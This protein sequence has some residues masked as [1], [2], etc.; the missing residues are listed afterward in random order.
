MAREQKELINLIKTNTKIIQIV[1]YKTLRIHA[2]LAN[3]ASEL[4]REL[5]LWNRVEEIKKWDTEKR[6]WTVF[7]EAREPET[8]FAFF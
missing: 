7:E 3:A 2:Y 4:G 5:Y 8:V 1:S 6:S